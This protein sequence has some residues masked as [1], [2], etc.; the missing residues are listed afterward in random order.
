[1]QE[2]T[3]EE[4]FLNGKPVPAGTPAS[5]L[6][7]DV[8]TSLRKS[9][10]LTNVGG[11]TQTNKAATKKVA[12]KKTKPAKGKKTES[13]KP[14]S[15]EKSNEDPDDL[16]TID[17]LGLPAKAIKAIADDANANLE[18]LGDL[19]KFFADNGSFEKVHNIGEALSGEMVETLGLGGESAGDGDGEGSTE[20]D[21]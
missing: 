2:I 11:E 19:R 16:V 13:A 21:D 1:M 9:Q 4:L 12:A 8:L 17:K 3:T 6:P 5:D 7:D 20:G 15:A 18:T 14:S 10:K